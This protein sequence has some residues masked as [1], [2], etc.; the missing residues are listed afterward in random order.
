MAF[1]IS[2]IVTSFIYTYLY[3]QTNGSIFSTIL[4]HWVYTYVLQVVSSSIV[5]NSLYNWLEV[6]PAVIIGLV[7]AFKMRNDKGFDLSKKEN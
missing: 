5:R 4:L 3:K 1:T 7:F 2:V 6:I